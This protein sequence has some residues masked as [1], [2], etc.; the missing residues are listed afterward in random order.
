M[1]NQPE[2]IALLPKIFH[3]RGLPSTLP[4][5]AI[6]SHPLHPPR[7]SFCCVQ[8]VKNLNLHLSRP[9]EGVKGEEREGGRWHCNGNLRSG[10]N[11]GRKEKHETKTSEKVRG[12]WKQGREE[13][14]GKGER[15]IGRPPRRRRAFVQQRGG[16]W[17]E[18]IPAVCRC[19]I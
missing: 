18:N 1:R 7:A 11:E 2:S 12:G 10:G 15:E 17:G 9:P 4:C 5:L 6:G 14:K 8:A 3:Q 16:I 19:H 13:G